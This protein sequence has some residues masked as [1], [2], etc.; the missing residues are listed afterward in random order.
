MIIVLFRHASA[1][2]RLYVLANAHARLSHANVAE[3]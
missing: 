2:S 1:R 3:W